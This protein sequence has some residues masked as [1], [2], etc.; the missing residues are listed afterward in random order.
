MIAIAHALD[1]A[2]RARK[3]GN[4]AALAPAQQDEVLD[5]LSRGALGTKLPENPLFR[6]LHGLTL[7]GFLADPHHGGNKDMIA[8]KAIGF[9]EPT[10]RSRGNG[11][12][13]EHGG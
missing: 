10:L 12:G 13:H 2:A 1:D 5:A 7:E 11:G 6:V 3:A 9:T 8:W 4:F